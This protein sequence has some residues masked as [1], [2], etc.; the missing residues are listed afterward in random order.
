MKSSVK[1]IALID[2]DDKIH[3]VEFGP[4]V[5]IITGKSST[6]KSAMIEIFDYC[7]GNEDYTVPE[8]IITD[9]A[10]LYFVVMELP[11]SLLVLARKPKSKHAF[12]YE[13]TVMEEVTIENF[14]IDYFLDFIP[15]KEFKKELSRT[16]G[17]DI[18]DTDTDLEDRKFRWN[19]AKKERPTARHFM[20]FVLQHQNLIANKHSLFYRFDEKEKRDQTIDQFKIFCGFVDQDYFVKSQTLRELQRKIRLAETKRQNQNAI[21]SSYNI[22]LQELFAD[23]HAITGTQLIKGSV[24]KLLVTPTKL[25]ANVA[26]SNV[27]SDLESDQ[28]LKRRNNLVSVQSQVAARLRAHDRELSNVK[29]SIRYGQEYKDQ[30][31]QIKVVENA[32]VTTSICPFCH[33]DSENLK[34]EANLLVDSIGWLNTELRKASYVTDSFK[35]DEKR[36]NVERKEVESELKKVNS[37]IA[38]LDSVIKKLEENKSINEQ[39]TIIKFRIESMLE[40]IVELNSSEAEEEFE[41]LNRE[42]KSLEKDL[43]ENYNTSQ[44]LN[45]AEKI[46]NKRMNE[47]GSRLDFEKSYQPINLQFDLKTFELY[48]EKKGGEKIFLRSMGSGANW[49]YSHLCLFLSLQYYFCTLK[50]KCHI[51]TILFLD[52]PSQVYFPSI[53]DVSEQFDPTTLKRQTANKGK[54]TDDQIAKDADDDIAAVTNMYNE[55]VRH[56][57]TT[58]NDTGILPQIIVTDHADNL[59]LNVEKV[60]F[61]DLVGGRRWRKKGFIS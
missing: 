36:I 12:I 6:G 19:S 18:V 34:N 3:Q 25:L 51:P 24:E 55:L 44:K 29:Y 58:L 5:N 16:F 46:I 17:I 54:A 22:R 4:G 47:I 30:A 21:I 10:K 40:E 48:H 9:S 49:L 2:K 61:D 26:N 13:D 14:T 1:Y 43:R 57:L 50:N 31:N 8:G 20:S 53:I 39:G 7:F 42:I 60:K 28:F 38:S 35:A 11:Q 56:A 59:K 33:N 52:Q 41:I 27:V 32:T 45:R 15:L 23:Y 37:E